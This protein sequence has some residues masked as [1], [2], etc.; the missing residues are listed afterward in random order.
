MP[1]EVRRG[2]VRIVTNY[3]RLMITLSLGVVFV[4]LMCGWVGLEAFGLVALVG[5]TTGFAAMVA[6][7]AQQGVIRELGSAWHKGDPEYFQRFYNTSYVLSAAAGVVAAVIV[8]VA[9]VVVPLLDIPPDWVGPARWIVA[10]QGVYALVSVVTAPAFSMYLVL[11]RFTAYNWWQVCTR[12]TQLISLVILAYGVGITDTVVALKWYGIV[13]ATLLTVTLLLA[14]A[15]IIWRNRILRPRLHLADRA[16]FRQI[17]HT[18]GWSSLAYLGL[19]LHERC[20]AILMNLAFGVFGNG[21]FA[22]SNRLAAYVRMAVTG[23]TCGL[24]AV[25]ARISSGQDEDVR[26]LIHHMTRLQALIAIPGG[27]IIFVLAEPLLT[28]WIARNI[29]NPERAIPLAVTIVQILAFAITSRAIAHGWMMMLYG[30]GHVRHYAPLVMGAGIVSPLLG[31]VFLFV[32]PESIRMNA[33][34]MGY[35]AALTIGHLIVLPAIGQRCLGMPYR[36]F[37]LPMVRPLVATGICAP[38]PI[39]A[40]EFI[41]SWTLIHLAAVGA[42][43]GLAYIPVCWMFVLNSAE[44]SR[45]M[46]AIRHR[47]PGASR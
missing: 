22:V 17:M 39:L 32:L 16:A 40:S 28:L 47:L 36:D 25:T 15:T 8:L 34:A 21:V 9:W 29:E 31:G 41:E 45:V 5:A 44:R 42:A 14:V 26:A 11:E 1:S 43:F 24:D 27:L 23:V 30:A 46:A 13:W 38:I 7:M 35:S 20:A 33:P 10:T 12:S 6:E 37:I 19:S 4:R 3:A 2:F 18:F